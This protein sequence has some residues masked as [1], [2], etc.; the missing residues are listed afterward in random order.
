MRLDEQSAK[1][2]L[3]QE[4]TAQMLWKNLRKARKTL[5]EKSFGAK[6]NKNGVTET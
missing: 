5:G 2:F 6:A 4:L 3:M 1:A